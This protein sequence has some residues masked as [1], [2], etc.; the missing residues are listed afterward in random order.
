MCG[1]HTHTRTPQK[2]KTTEGAGGRTSEDCLVIDAS[3]H[4]NEMSFMNDFRDDAFSPP[5]AGTVS[6]RIYH[7][8]IYQ[9]LG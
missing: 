9:C 3:L 7:Y 2:T 4:R 8:M 1:Q 5:P 6:L